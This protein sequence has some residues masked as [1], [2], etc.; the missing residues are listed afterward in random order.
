MRSLQDE[1]EHND[2]KTRF[3]LLILGSLNAINLV[4]AMRGD[5][6]GLLPATGA[7]VAVYLACYALV[8]L[9]CCFFAITA[10]KPGANSRTDATYG[11]HGRRPLRFPQ[12]VLTQT[13]D[14]YCENWRTAEVGP[15]RRNWRR[16]CIS[17]HART[18][19]DSRRCSA[20]TSVLRACCAHRRLVALAFRFV[21]PG[22]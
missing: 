16:S 14:E 3:A 6:I 10:L 13:L 4:I 15:L 22:L 1:A 18:P 8:S 12:P 20:S 17:R 5:T 11:S 7:S 19:T 21:A 2:K 9:G